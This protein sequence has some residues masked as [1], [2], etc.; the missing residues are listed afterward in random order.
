MMKDAWSFEECVSVLRG[1]IE[2]LKKISSA[3]FSVRSAVLAKEWAAFEEKTTEVNALGEEFTILEEQR[4]QLFS[5]L[6]S[7]WSGRRESDEE[8]VPFYT[9][10][11]CLPN[12]EASEL[13][14]L[15]RELKSETSIMKALN[16][17]L[18]AYVNE[19]KVMA[20]AYLEAICPGRGGK[21]YTRKGQRASQ[22]LKSMVFNNQL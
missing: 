7:K 17:S 6:K 15:Y 18:L 21:L 16:E 3:Q 8:T 4:I 20:A 14:F 2:I 22:D 13:S 10:I 9:L 1:E 19:A 12:K 11:T 5:A